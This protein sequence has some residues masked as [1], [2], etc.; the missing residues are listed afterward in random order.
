MK[1][2]YPSEWGSQMSLCKTHWLTELIVIGVTLVSVLL[3]T[4]WQA[5]LWAVLKFVGVVTLFL[6]A[7]GVMVFIGVLL[8]AGIGDVCNS[9]GKT[10]W[11]QRHERT[12]KTCIAI[13]AVLAVV[14]GTI[15]SV[16]YYLAVDPITA[17]LICLK[18][19]VMAM[20]VLAAVAALA[21]AFVYCIATIID[22]LED[23]KLF[24]NT[25]FGQFARSAKEGLCP[26]LYECGIDTA[27]QD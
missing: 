17:L 13:G 10:Q 5:G 4:A 9:I 16:A 15:A 20:W 1:W 19:L 24:T 2:I 21:Y 14:G 27:K 23:T 6:L 22:W 12:L 25:A 3:Y 8:G 11:H 18:V 7:F 26:T